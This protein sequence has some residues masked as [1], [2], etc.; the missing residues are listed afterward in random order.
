MTK[1]QDPQI[2]EWTKSKCIE[3]IRSIHKKGKTI[4]LDN[5]Q[6]VQSDNQEKVNILKT[7][8]SNKVFKRELEI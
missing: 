5:L 2:S 6:L 1:E 7:P 3:V 4:C 8:K